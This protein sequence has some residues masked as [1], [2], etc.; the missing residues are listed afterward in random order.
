MYFVGSFSPEV[1]LADL[2]YELKGVDWYQLGVQLNVPVHVLTNID[3]ENRS[4]SRKLSKVLD[5]WIKNAKLEASWN[6]IINALQRIGGHENIIAHVQYKYGSPATSQSTSC[7]IVPK[8]SV[9]E[10]DVHYVID[11]VLS[12][13]DQLVQIPS[14]FHDC[15]CTDAHLDELSKY[16]VDDW[17]KLSPFLCLSQGEV[18]EIVKALPKETNHTAPPE[19]TSGS[20]AMLREWRRKFGKNAS[21]R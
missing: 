15:L 9:A 14:E 12:L 18:G 5:Y 3:L 17:K 13:V 4:E 11:R 21:Y 10:E 1:K 2:V 20:K 8:L 19:D 6:V 16:I 7:T